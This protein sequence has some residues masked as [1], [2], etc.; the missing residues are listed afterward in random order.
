MPQSDIATI[1]DIVRVH[2]MKRPDAVALVIDDRTITF[3]EL[4]ARSS[5]AAQAFLTA[6]VGFGDRVA[7]VEKNGA[8][9]FEVVCG[10]AKLGAVAVPVNWR[11]A[12]QE[13]LHII[14]DAQA[15]VVVVGAEFFG[16]IEAI[17]NRLGIIVA[18]GTHG[19]WPDFNAWLARQPAEDPGVT[20]GPDD[21]AFL[22]YTSGTT[23]SP[24]GVMLSNTNYLSK[25]TGIAEQWRF[26]AD[27]VSSP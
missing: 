10:L 25:A 5:Q 1:A 2:S 14:E 4:D 19:R 12:A 15:K 9:F 3:A 7:F 26:D 11:L 21:V 22:M 27:S 13:M 20:T 16:Q 17:E 8:E 23:G 24:K 6:G 18:I